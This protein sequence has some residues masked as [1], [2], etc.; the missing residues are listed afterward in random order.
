MPL[1]VAENVARNHSGDCCP[2]WPHPHPAGRLPSL[3][4]QQGS[5][6]QLAGAGWAPGVGRVGVGT[7]VG[8]PVLVGGSHL[9]SEQGRSDRPFHLGG[10]PPVPGPS[11]PGPSCC[12][13]QLAAG[14]GRPEP[15]PGSARQR[16][17]APPTRHADR[18]LSGSCFGEQASSMPETAEN[19]ALPSAP[20]PPWG[21]LGGGD[22]QSPRPLPEMR[23]RHWSAPSCC[24]VAWFYLCPQI[25]Q[26]NY[27][28]LKM[29]RTQ[30]SRFLGAYSVH[31]VLSHGKLLYIHLASRYI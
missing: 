13:G 14:P 11:P 24:S 31:T 9:S 26:K 5:R 17:L 4:P 18:N 22:C 16:N 15:A 19:P 27:K 30:K 25:F 23:H 28:I 21:D 20:P 12:S 1:P 7:G 10:C 6:M 8:G 2:S 29:E 3:A